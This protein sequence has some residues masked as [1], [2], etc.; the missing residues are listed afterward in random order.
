MAYCLN[1][2][3]PR[4]QNPE[5]GR[6]CL[7][8]GAILALSDRYVA[9]RL[10]GRG[11]FGRTFLGLDRQKPSHP[12]CVIK[13]LHPE[14]GNHS[15]KAVEL[16]AQEARRLEEL[17]PHPQ[18]PDLY[19]YCQQEQ[20]QYIVQEF[21]DGE[22]L[23]TRF[24]RQ[25]CFT[26]LEIVALLK[27]LLP[28][29]E[30]IHRGQVI[31]RDI[32]PDNILQ[33]R[34]DGLLLLVDFGAAKLVGEGTG[35]RIGS[36]G[37]TAPEQLMG[38]AVFA[39]DLYSLGATCLYLL[40]GIA[41]HALY[42]P[43]TETFDW[44]HHGNGSLVPASLG[45]LLDRLVAPSLKLRAASAAA[46][47]EQL[48]A[49][50]PTLQ[51]WLQQPH[52]PPPTGDWGCRWQVKGVTGAVRC[53]HWVGDWVIAGSDRAD[54]VVLAAKT[55]AVVWQGRHA[56]AWVPRIAMAEPTVVKHLATNA[57]AT[58]LATAGTDP[59]I[60]LWD[61]ATGKLLRTLRG[62]TAAVLGVQFTPDGQGLRSFGADCQLLEW[63]VSKNSPQRS[64]DLRAQLPPP[65]ALSWSPDGELGAIATPTTLCFFNAVAACVL[66][67]WELPISGVQTLQWLPNGREL[68]LELEDGRLQHW[69]ISPPIQLAELDPLSHAFQGVITC[70]DRGLWQG[71]RAG[72]IYYYSANT[73][74]QVW[75]S[76]C[77]D[78]TCIASQSSGIALGTAQGT[79]ALWEPAAPKPPPKDPH[80]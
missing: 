15:L 66:A 11:G 19:A 38:K 16:F 74:Q 34:A 8:C 26:P 65:H 40:T 53:L 35:T 64:M 4:P 61:M 20:R 3:C 72:R 50:E 62:H 58:Y 47:L 70:N 68:L 25:G 73:L 67:G 45:Q 69:Q 2:D 56:P 80:L 13:Q 42:D 5:S 1:P 6:F 9:Q 27:S 63:V 77:P 10:L 36:L 31:H 30:F 23:G 32:K 55:G 52:L 79:I 28:V 54:V 12:P 78:M 57:A 39:S 43:A 44:R 18:I 71:D 37:F 49:I 33:R 59:L 24:E 21:I 29:L 76:H 22:D 7:A 75:S 48:A 14:A 60:H 46:V 41:P 17:G 51:P